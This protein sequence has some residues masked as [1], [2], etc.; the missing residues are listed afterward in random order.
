MHYKH[1]YVGWGVRGEVCAGH[2]CL[3]L[4]DCADRASQ[5]GVKA[6]HEGEVF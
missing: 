2:E 4:S 6:E 5:D 3:E 1:T